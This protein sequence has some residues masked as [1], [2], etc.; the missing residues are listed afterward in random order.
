MVILCLQVF[1]AYILLKTG[2][3][4]SVWLTLTPMQ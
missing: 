4:T 3:W 2:T 1:V